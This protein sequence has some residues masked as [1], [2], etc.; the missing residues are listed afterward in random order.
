MS[1][2]TPAQNSGGGKAAGVLAVTLDV[3]FDLTLGRSVMGLLVQVIQKLRAKIVKFGFGVNRQQ[4]NQANVKA[5]EINHPRTAPLAHT[6]TLPAYL[7]QAGCARYHVTSHR[8]NGDP[9][10][11]FNAFTVLPN[12]IGNAREI[13]SFFD[14]QYKLIV[15]PNNLEKHSSLRSRKV[16]CES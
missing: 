14:G 10:D 9:V 13:L 7:A 11:K 1:G 4:H 6:R 15:R 3:T 16:V 8:V 12:A 5:I 2:S